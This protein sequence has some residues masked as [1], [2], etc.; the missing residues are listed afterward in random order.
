MLE[1]LLGSTSCLE[2]AILVAQAQDVDLKEIG[3]WSRGEG[4]LD[5]FMQIQALLTA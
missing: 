3:R 2:Q 5:A 4:K 1:V